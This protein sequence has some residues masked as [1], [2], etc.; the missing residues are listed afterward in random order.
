M[1]R[2][3]AIEPVADQ[4]REGGSAVDRAIGWRIDYFII[5]EIV[6]ISKEEIIEVVN[7]KAI[8]HNEQIIPSSPGYTGM[9][10]PSLAQ[11][12]HSLKRFIFSLEIFSK[13]MIDNFRITDG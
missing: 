5:D 9:V 11:F 1:G 6:K 7:K 10:K 4:I 12:G 13:N 8:R 2:H 3:D